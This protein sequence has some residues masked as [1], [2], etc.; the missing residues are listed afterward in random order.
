MSF[1]NGYP[2]VWVPNNEVALPEV[3]NSYVTALQNNNVDENLNDIF[4]KNVMMKFDINPKK[5][6]E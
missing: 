2:V 5:F 1:L 6:F 3:E 4:M